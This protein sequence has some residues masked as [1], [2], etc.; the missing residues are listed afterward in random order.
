[1]LSLG[2]GPAA[3]FEA[4]RRRNLRQVADGQ[5]AL[6]DATEVVSQA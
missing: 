6:A 2:F 1:M 5:S 4:E 3:W